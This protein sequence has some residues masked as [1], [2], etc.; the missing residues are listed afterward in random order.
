[1]KFFSTGQGEMDQWRKKKKRRRTRGLGSEVV[2]ARTIWELLRFL[3]GTSWT[4]P[5]WQH[6]M[7]S[8]PSACPQVWRGQTE[9]LAATG[10]EVLIPPS[11]VRGTTSEQLHPPTTLPLFTALWFVFDW[12][13]TGQFYHP[14]PPSQPYW[15]VPHRG[16]YGEAD[17]MFGPPG[18]QSHLK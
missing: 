10:S 18:D 2:W 14:P 9:M 1:M 5:K 13:S 6:I 12:R 15:I 8:I 17:R 7:K 4:T 11:I 16:V 3:A